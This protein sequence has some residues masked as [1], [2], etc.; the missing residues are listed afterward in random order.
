MDA[1]LKILSTS[2]AGIT[3]F[4]DAYMLTYIADNYTLWTNL[5]NYQT[6]AVLYSKW[7][8]H[9]NSVC[10]CITIYSSFNKAD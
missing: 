3:S 2:C 7:F 5:R 1:S 9:N 10:M 4:S 8:D 6:P